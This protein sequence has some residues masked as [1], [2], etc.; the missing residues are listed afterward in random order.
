MWDKI[1]NVR[2][3]CEKL[4]KDKF[5]YFRGIVDPTRT[6]LKNSNSDWPD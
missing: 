5:R 6:Q 2:W 3:M 1:E 4:E